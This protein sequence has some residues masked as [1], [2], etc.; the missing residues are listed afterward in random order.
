MGDH[1]DKVDKAASP[2]PAPDPISPELFNLDYHDASSVAE[3]VCSSSHDQPEV[4][5]I[6]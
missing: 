3:S 2:P 4:D 1:P 5:V 6:M